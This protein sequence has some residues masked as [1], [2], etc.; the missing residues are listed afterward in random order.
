M[1]GGGRLVRDWAIGL[2]PGGPPPRQPRSSQEWPFR[3]FSLHVNGVRCAFP[4]FCANRLHSVRFG[5]LWMP[6]LKT[7]SWE[8]RPVGSP[9]GPVPVSGTG[10]S[11]GQT[12]LVRGL[13]CFAF[14]WSLF[15]KPPRVRTSSVTVLSLKPSICGEGPHRGCFVI[16]LLLWWV[17][18]VENCNVL[19]VFG[20]SLINL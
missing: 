15:P 17:G 5:Q 16:S 13:G 12:A 2:D 3:S 7:F 1:G 4:V 9:W 6:P 11:W 10:S 19:M 18:C 8:T 14:V 20:I